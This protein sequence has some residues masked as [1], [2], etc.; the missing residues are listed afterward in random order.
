MTLAPS[1][2]ME[3]ARAIADQWL[4]DFQGA[5]DAG[6]PAAAAALFLPDGYLR[7]LLAL[8]WDLRTFSGREAITEALKDVLPS[9]TISELMSI[10]TSRSAGV[11]FS[12]D[13]ASSR[14]APQPSSR[15]ISI[16]GRIGT[17][18]PSGPFSERFAILVLIVVLAVV[19]FFL[20]S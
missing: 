15:M 16:S 9:R 3:Q 1:L 13:L 6:D 12:S 4:A 11:L 7:D 5:I 10:R 20:V 8:T 2:T 14:F 19:V 18:T 17:R